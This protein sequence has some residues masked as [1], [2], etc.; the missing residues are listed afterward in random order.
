MHGVVFTKLKQFVE[1][2]FDSD[3]W[4]AILKEAGHED[5]MFVPIKIYSDETLGQIAAAA[6][7]L[8]GIARD[9]LLRAFGSFLA[10]HLMEM[11]GALIPADWRTE[12]LLMNVEETIHRVVRMK[13]PAPSRQSWNSPDSEAGICSWIIARSD[14]CRRWRMASCSAL[15]N[16]TA[17]MLISTRLIF[18]AACRC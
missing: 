9:D 18:P 16:I 17:S 2:T 15:P 8:S 10:P 3:T 1:E 5:E 4:S 7:K 13:I 14:V 11:Y 12:S 6:V